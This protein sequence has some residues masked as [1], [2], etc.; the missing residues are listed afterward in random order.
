MDIETRRAW[1]T[2]PIRAAAWIAA[3][4]ACY[5]LSTGPAVY[6]TIRGKISDKAFLT[7]YRPLSALEAEFAEDFLASYLDWWAKRALRSTER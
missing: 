2:G 7:M 3:I 5:V 6:L 1:I 4:V